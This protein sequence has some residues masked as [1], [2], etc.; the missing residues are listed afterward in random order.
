M[1]TPY[2]GSTAYSLG[3]Q[4]GLVPPSD[5]EGWKHFVHASNQ[6]PWMLPDQ[7]TFVITSKIAQKALR[8]RHRD[9]ARFRRKKIRGA[10]LYAYSAITRARYRRGY[11][12]F[13]IEQRLMARIA[14]NVI[15]S[16]YPDAQN[17]GMMI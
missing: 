11:F 2:P 15:S 8:G 5:L 4:N 7:E 14:K 16:R 10:L 13:P 3:L 6:V 9:R 17:N 12:G 1:Y